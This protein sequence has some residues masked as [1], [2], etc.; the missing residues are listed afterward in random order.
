MPYAFIGAIAC[1]LLGSARSTHDFDIIVLDG[2]NDAALR[3][4]ASN[5]KAFGTD[6]RGIWAKTLDGKQYNLDIIEPSVYWRR[7]HCSQ[8]SESSASI[9]SSAVQTVLICQ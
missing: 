8:R 5:S 3:Q 6:G 7:C 4:L 9:G 1:S 2:Q